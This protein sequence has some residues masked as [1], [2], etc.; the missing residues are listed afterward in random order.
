M[1]VNKSKEN[2]IPQAKAIVNEVRKAII[3]KDEII[4]KILVAIAANGHILLDDIPGVG[5]TT[6]ALAFSKAMSLDYKRMQF[7]PDVM[8]AD[9]TGFNIYN[10]DTG[11]FEYKPGA[12][13]CS[14]FLADEINRTSSKTQSALL[15]LMEEG[16]VTVDGVTRALPKPFIVIATQNPIGSVG[17][18]S[19]PESQLDR[20]IIRLS[21]GYPSSENE[22]A[23]L[24]SKTMAQA[25]SVF[26][27]VTGDDIIALQY[28][29]DEVF[30]DDRIYKYMVDL[31]NATRCDSRIRLGLSPR[32][33]LA[34]SSMAKAA[35]LFHA[36][37]YVIP[38]DVRYV[39]NDVAAHRIILTSKAKA[40]GHTPEK[41]LE[42]IL[43]SADAP[44]VK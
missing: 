27:V 8:P 19:L 24:K 26:P 23:I 36:R 38:D 6:L 42:D 43:S 17:T 40:A 30:A 16:S 3:G 15:E 11:K 31:A 35:A 20:F 13:M 18:Q 1:T 14:M 44:S 21:M 39:F 2:L 33:T 10:K 5:K 34:L 41:V 7:T 12:A 29:A 4:I 28:A 32:G 25:D 22:V 37:E 9:V